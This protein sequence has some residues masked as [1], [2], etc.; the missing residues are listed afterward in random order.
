MNLTCYDIDIEEIIRIGKYLENG[1]ERRSEE[2]GSPAKPRPMLVTI[3]GG[4]KRRIMRNLYR[5]KETTNQI[6][7]K[8]GVCHDMSREEREREIEL[9]R[10][11]RDKNEQEKES[12]NFYVVRG[13]PWKR[14]LLRVDRKRQEN[15]EEARI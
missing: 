5:L 12:G 8:V 7:K 2:R 6:F 4:L 15:K 9:R 14:Y 11:A 13:N 3:N 10:E 1:T